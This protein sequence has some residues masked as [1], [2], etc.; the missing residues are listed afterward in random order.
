MKRFYFLS[1]LTG[2]IISLTG[3]LASSEEALAYAFP[4]KAVDGVFPRHYQPERTVD[5]E[6]LNLEI[7]VVMAEKR[8]EGTAHYLLKPVNNTVKKI[9]FDAN[10]MKIKTV[11]SNDY[12]SLT[13]N[14]TENVLYID[15][16]EALKTDKSV[17]L[18]ISYS[19]E[20][21][22]LDGKFSSGMHFT[23]SKEVDGKTADQM[24]TIAE[25]FGASVWFPCFDYPS[26]R[27]TTEILVT[28]PKEFTTLSNGKLLESKIEG[29]W[30]TDHWKQEIPHSTYLVSLAAG[31]FDIV[32]DEW[33][34]IPVEYYV[35][36]GLAKEARP[37]MGKTP[38]MIDFLSNFVDYPYPYEKYAQVAARYFTAGGMEHTTCT[39]M[40][41]QIVMDA[42]ARLDT[43]MEG[44]IV[45]ELCHQWFGDLVTCKN[46]GELWL[47]EGFATYSEPLW[48]EHTEGKDGYLE[49]VFGDME[50]YINSS[51]AYTRPIVTNTF[52]NA[53]EMFDGHS[54][55]KGGS[56]LHMLRQ[57]LG[58]DLFRK[59]LHNYLKKNAPGMVDTHE[60]MDA[61]EE[62]TGKPM[63]RF[64]EQWIYRPGHPVIEA[65]H[66]WLADK[67]QV[68]V[69][70]KQTQ[71]MNEG[72]APFTFPLDIEVRTD[73]QTYLKT[74]QIEKKE[75]SVFIDC[76]KA[77][78]SVVID[79]NLKVLMEL[80]HKKNQDMLLFDLEKGSSV[81][82]KIRAIRGLADHRQPEVLS[83]LYN[84]A[85]N[86]SNRWVRLEAI[87]IL[88]KERTPQVLSW[89]IDLAKNPD[90]KIR[91]KAVNNM[92]GF[93]KDSKAIDE[94]I[95]IAKTDPASN[96]AADAIRV[97]GNLKAEKAVP[98]IRD[99]LKRNSWNNSICTASMNAL[100]NLKEDRVFPDL[101]R[102]SEDP[103]PREIQ[104]AALHCLGSLTEKT[105]KHQP[106]TMERLLV[107]LKSK[108]EPIRSAAI[109]AL[110][111]AK[112]K[113]AIPQLRWVQQNDSDKDLREAAE[114]AISETYK[115]Q[116]NELAGKNAGRID[117]LEDQNKKL[118]NR[119][120]ELET[121]I[122][123][124]S[125][126]N[127]SKPGTE[128]KN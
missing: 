24:F 67:N 10:K 102:L 23:N 15:F 30:K 44:L 59:S 86:E 36:K 70:L 43:D 26:D 128:K 117:T 56:V 58:D 81:I 115:D 75:E 89:L 104:T 85:K 113:D 18:D 94:L 37:S 111:S 101:L 82:V 61:I 97:L 2:V 90:A 33:K 12:P 7:K 47:N 88:G 55:P 66:E 99:G 46:W 76:P 103:N 5:F 110:Q 52:E 68:K 105:K 77:P 14:Y 125:K 93:Y 35:E 38:E 83:V 22:R 71:K 41:Q 54:Y 19:S 39:T 16:P 60:L 73:D 64:F 121:K 72:D 53:D 69:T 20:E 100:V 28:V 31:H 124:L 32:R 87:E 9:R 92:D 127:E 8:I 1:I 48:K 4:P 17:N 65:N 84:T 122:E 95:R 62:T 13:W 50:T 96:V 21:P 107:A 120:K 63:N 29:D 106:E 98:V 126:K 112:L 109:G 74:V 91:R 6:H 51:R 79:P 114:R 49:A 119:V 42:S 27:L 123:Q 57:E 40:Y 25:P 108:S 45:H 118:E 80:N 116:G 78:K 11:Q 3:L 34:G